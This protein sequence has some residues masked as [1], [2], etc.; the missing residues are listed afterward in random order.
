MRLLSLLL[1][2]AIIA[3]LAL[4]LSVIWMLRDQKDKTR[5]LLVFALTLNVFF[6]FLL[7]V[8]MGREGGLLPW[9]YDHILFAM[10]SALGVSAAV[11]A[12]LLQGVCRIPLLVIYQLMVPMMICWFLVTRYRNTRGSVVLAYIG[13]LVAGPLLYAVLPGCG[14]IY[15][16][17]AQWLNPPLVQANT[18]RLAAMPNAFPS[19]H[20]ATAFVF[21]LFAP[22]RAS[23]KP[24]SL[25]FLA[26]TRS[27]RSQ[28][29]STTSSTSLQGWS[30]AASPR[31]VGYSKFRRRASLSRSRPRL[32]AHGQICIPV[33]HRTSA[34]ASNDGCAHGGDGGASG[35]QGMAH[36]GW[37]LRS[38]RRLTRLERR[39]R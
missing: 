16:F 39:V 24:S 37:P 12:R 38:G 35:I 14:P 28:P 23:R 4:F 1:N 34:S 7:T 20:I 32:V 27:P 25:A 2:P 10:D 3:T 6:G 18:I 11:I 8:F 13:E 26:G 5:P 31:A 22:G 33:S 29:A 30:S 19:L 17:G 36:S 21:V 15:A 9:K